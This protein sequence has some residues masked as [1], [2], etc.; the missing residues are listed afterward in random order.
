MRFVQQRHREGKR[1]LK[2]TLA[3]LSHWP[4][5]I[6]E[7]LRILLRGGTAVERFE[8]SFEI[9]RSPTGMSPPYSVR[10]RSSSSIRSSPHN[11]PK[12]AIGWWR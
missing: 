4:A 8:D 10:S 9:E 2:H 11:G 3:N 7:G 1:V 6:V 12:N 5:E